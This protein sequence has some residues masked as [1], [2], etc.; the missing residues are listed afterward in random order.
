MSAG[1]TGAGE[2]GAEQTGS[3]TV[4]SLT[5]LWVADL[6]RAVDFYVGGCGFTEASRF[7]GR[8]FEAAILR[9]GDAGLELMVPV[10]D[11]SGDS[12]A[13]SRDAGGFNKLVLTVDDV[14][15]RLA[16]ATEHGGTVEMP[17]TTVEQYGLV[18]GMVRDPDGYLVEM[19]RATG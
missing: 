6:D 11:S 19:T 16:A 7:P 17:A 8:G 3:K 2:T 4:L 18:I 5:A 13:A 10:S 12:A 15:A 14:E 9:A 1:E